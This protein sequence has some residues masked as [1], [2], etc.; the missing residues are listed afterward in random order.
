MAVLAGH[1]LIYHL[2]TLTSIHHRYLQRRVL[3]HHITPPMSEADLENPTNRG[4]RGS[5]IYG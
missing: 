1:R 4:A 2:I 3:L 5:D